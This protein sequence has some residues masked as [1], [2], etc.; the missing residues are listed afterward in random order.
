MNMGLKG[1]VIEEV[2]GDVGFGWMWVW[3]GFGRMWDWEGCC[4]GKDVRFG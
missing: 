4:I 3:A 2:V 1:C